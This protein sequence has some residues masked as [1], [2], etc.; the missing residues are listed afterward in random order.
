[1]RDDPRDVHPYSQTHLSGFSGSFS[2]PG[3]ISAAESSARDAFPSQSVGGHTLLPARGKAQH[4]AR[5]HS[6]G[7]TQAATN[8]SHWLG[9]KGWISFY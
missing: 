4:P 7:G 6:G 5:C 9:A 8:A 2:L 1:M 3:V